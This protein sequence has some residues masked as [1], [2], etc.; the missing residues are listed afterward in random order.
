MAS[1]SVSRRSR[2]GLQAEHAVD[3]QERL[4]L[5]ACREVVTGFHAAQQVRGGDGVEVLVEGVAD[6]RGRVGGY[7][8]GR[9][10]VS[11]RQ[12]ST[13]I[14]SNEADEKE[15]I[16]TPCTVPS[17]EATVTA[18]TPVGNEPIAFRKAFTSTVEA[19]CESMVILLG[20]VSEGQ[21]A[22][23]EVAGDRARGGGA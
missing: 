22:A 7:R 11:L 4:E 3:E 14:G 23:G 6:R 18:V 10:A 17:T 12:T 13:S 21:R 5:R 20:V 16:V 19:I 9:L 15:L 8:P 2:R 1:S